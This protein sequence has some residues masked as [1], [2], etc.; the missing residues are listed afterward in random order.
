MS[1]GTN[2]RIKQQNWARLLPQ[3]RR[4]GLLFCG[5]VRSVLV[6]RGGYRLEGD[7]RQY[8]RS[9]DTLN[10][11]HARNEH[12]EQGSVFR[13]LSRPPPYSE[14]D[15]HA[16]LALQLAAF[17][18]VMPAAR[19]NTSAEWRLWG[20]RVFA[21][22]YQAMPTGKW[23]W[24]RGKRP[25]ATCT[26]CVQSDLIDDC[27]HVVHACSAA[28]AARRAHFDELLAT[29][30]TREAIMLRRLIGEMWA[31]L[32]STPVP[33]ALLPVEVSQRMSDWPPRQKNA[34]SRLT[35]SLAAIQRSFVLSAWRVLR[36]RTGL[37]GT[38]DAAYSPCL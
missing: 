30:A 35:A 23:L 33:V 27:E 15:P 2:A 5:G 37:G 19:P 18:V 12:R 4:A 20:R 16:D 6:A 28:A 22:M 36:M 3:Q 7:I 21:T 32:A 8:V 14:A 38:S 10:Q 17:P 29:A 26:R 11:L 24:H 31:V 9:N 13:Q 25:V 34:M 1:P